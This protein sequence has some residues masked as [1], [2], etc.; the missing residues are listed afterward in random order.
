MRLETLSG[1]IVRK[2]LPIVPWNNRDIANLL[3]RIAAK[4]IP[5]DI[6]TIRALRMESNHFAT[7]LFAI[8][9]AIERAIAAGGCA[10]DDPFQI[11][12]P[13]NA[14]SPQLQLAILLKLRDDGF[15]VRPCAALQLTQKWRIS[16]RIKP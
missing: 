5:M 6:K 9:G 4:P 12:R 14:V 8:Y 11:L 3:R 16:W 1:Q 15:T 2:K 13:E 10:I 7:A